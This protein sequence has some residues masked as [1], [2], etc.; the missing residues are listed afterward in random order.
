MSAKESWDA[1]AVGV[2]VGYLGR[3]FGGTSMPITRF[4]MFSIA[5]AISVR[6]GIV[7]NLSVMSS[8]STLNLVMFLSY[9]TITLVLEDP[10]YTDAT[11]PHVLDDVIVHAFIP[12]D[13]FFHAAFVKRAYTQTSFVPLLTYFA[14][15]SPLF[16]LTRPY[17]FVSSGERA[18]ITLTL[19]LTLA[20]IVH[21]VSRI[22]TKCVLNR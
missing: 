17:P 18:V 10:F 3:M 6:L 5:L 4:T 13:L 19:T 1:L 12:L 7:Q 9:W 14:I 2:Y 22:T 16:L 11:R 21:L 15:Y 20:L 8:I